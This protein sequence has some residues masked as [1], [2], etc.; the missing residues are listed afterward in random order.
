MLAT[1]L[2]ITLVLVLLALARLWAKSARIGVELAHEAGERARL[3]VERDQLREQVADL[4]ERDKE[5]A[6]RTAVLDEK[7]R[8]LERLRADSEGQAE[9]ANQQ[10]QR[11]DLVAER[12]TRVQQ[13]VEGAATKS[14][15]AKAGAER[16]EQHLL[17]FTQRIANPQ[18]RGAFGEEALRNQLE[19][20]GLTEGRDFDRQVQEIGGA[21]RIDYVVHLRGTT[22]GLD[23]KFA[24]DPDLEGL[25]AALG[26]GDQERLADYAR[27]LIARAKELA[28]KEY[29][30]HIERS[31]SFVLMYVPVEGAQ[32]VLAALPKFSYEKFAIEHG[33]YIVTPLQ[34]GTTLGVIA[35]VAHLSRREEELADVTADLSGLAKELTKFSEQYARHGK[36]IASVVNSYND[37][38]AMLSSRGGLGRVARRAMGFAR[39]VFSQPEEPDIPEVR[40]D[41]PEIAAS[42]GELAEDGP[43]EEAA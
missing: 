34:L 9:K 29:W 41:V 1:V 6:A 37:G 5:L 3:E 40:T 21:R 16:I 11:L 12:L 7:E 18:S 42:Y 8:Q 39:R 4:S 24:L 33:V 43:A 13:V 35:D 27:K 25:S 26:E 19:L 36:Q 15:E 2:S 23:P 10:Q 20:L 30:A 14:G 22:V 28:R 38:A 32:Q 31:P 17:G